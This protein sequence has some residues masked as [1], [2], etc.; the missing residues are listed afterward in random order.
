VLVLD[1][2]Q[3][4]LLSGTLDSAA[5]DK[6]VSEVDVGTRPLPRYFAGSSKDCMHVLLEAAALLGGGVGTTAQLVQVLQLLSMVI[7]AASNEEARGFMKSRGR[8]LVKVL[9][10]AARQFETAGAAGGDG[11]GSKEAADGLF[12]VERIIHFLILQRGDRLGGWGGWGPSHYI[13]LGG[14]GNVGGTKG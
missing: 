5:F 10:L 13:W 11:Q 14:K 2:V 7:W 12:A 8:L 6:V 1:L 4:Y 9:V 3:M